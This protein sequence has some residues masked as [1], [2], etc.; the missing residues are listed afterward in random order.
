MFGVILLFSLLFSSQKREKNQIFW[1]FL[2]FWVQYFT[3]YEDN[4]A[5]LSFYLLFYMMKFEKN[6]IDD[7]ATHFLALGQKQTTV[8]SLKSH[9]VLFWRFCRAKKLNLIEEIT[10]QNIYEYLEL[11]RKTPTQKTSRYYGKNKFL[12]EKTVQSKIISI[13]KFFKFLNFRHD[14]W[15]NY[16]KIE[17][18]RV[19]LPQMEYLTKEEL[20]QLFEHIE[21]NEKN[22]ENRLRNLLFCKLAFISWM[23]LSELLSIKV[24]DILWES[25]EISIVGKG[26]KI[27]PIYITKEIQ[28][29]ASEYV[30]FRGERNIVS[31]RSGHTRKMQGDWSL[32]FIRHDDYGFGHWLSK[33]TIVWIMQKY[34]DQLNFGKRI[35]CHMF[36]HSYATQ[37]L[38]NWANIRVV[39]E[40]LGHSS[41]ITTQRYTHITNNQLKEAHAKVFWLV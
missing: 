7:C 3:T 33:S 15:I 34:S 13:K 38:N 36:R 18:P 28:N 4:S 16:L 24:K 26:D 30:K 11:L 14:A 12:S 10:T 21:K 2:F 29:L 31:L 35:T 8:F 23:R 39:Q 20:F 40:M 6:L 9:L 41:I 19:H 17:I 1:L 32:L 22:E 25:R 37:L 5:T 27:R